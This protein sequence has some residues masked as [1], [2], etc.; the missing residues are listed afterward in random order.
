MKKCCGEDETAHKI[1]N[2][3]LNRLE[4]SCEKVRNVNEDKKII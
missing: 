1:L 4:S 3:K 2:K